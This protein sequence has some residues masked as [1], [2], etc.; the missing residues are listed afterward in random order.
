MIK[1]KTKNKET[2]SSMYF[3]M[4]VLTVTLGVVLGLTTIVVSQI[5]M[6]RSMHYSV[7][8]YYAADSGIEEALRDLF[9]GSG[10]PASTEN[11]SGSVG[12]ADFKADFNY[13]IYNSSEESCNK[14]YYCI[15]SIGE[16]KNIKR[17]IEVGR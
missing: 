3:A 16:Y 7:V 9:K 12:E 15:K 14:Q 10:L 4:M 17:A 13:T 2:G 6:V 8:A 11:G 5:K 1:T